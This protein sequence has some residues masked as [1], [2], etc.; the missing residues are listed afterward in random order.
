MFPSGLLLRTVE[1]LQLISITYSLALSRHH[2]CFR[3]E[4]YYCISLQIQII[5]YTYKQK[6]KTVY[7][8]KIVKNIIIHKL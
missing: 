2:K 6:I 7:E 8:Y 1:Y 3:V 4:I 5:A